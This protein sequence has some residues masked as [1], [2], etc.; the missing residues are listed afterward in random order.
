MSVEKSPQELVSTPALLLIINGALGVLLQLWS[1]GMSFVGSK[2]EL[3]ASMFPGMEPEMAD[4]F[5]NLGNS[6]Q[7]GGGLLMNVVFLGIAGF[8]LFGGL[9]MKSLESHGLAMAA[10]IV[11]IVPCFAC[12][13]LGIPAGIWS[14]IVLMKP[15]VK[16][17]F[18]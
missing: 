6:M 11:S 7:G 10:A 12:C 1:I 15:E 13:C 16:A 14:L 2:Q 3:D 4:M 9:K 5:V 17:G 18:Q 8:I